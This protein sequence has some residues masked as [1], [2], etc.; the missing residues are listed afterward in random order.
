MRDAQDLYIRILFAEGP[1]FVYNEY[2]NDPLPEVDGCTKVCPLSQ[3]DES[4]VRSFKISGV[5]G[6][7][8]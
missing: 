6:E 2:V 5:T 3:S 7:D 8:F 1:L 4:A